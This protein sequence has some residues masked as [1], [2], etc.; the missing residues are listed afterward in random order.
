MG[1]SGGM[2][3]GVTGLTGYLGGRLGPLVRAAGHELVD[4]GRPAG[5]DLLQP[6]TLVEAVTRLRPDAVIHTAAANPGRPEDTM[7]PVNRAASA[8]LAEITAAEG[9]RLV[10]VSSD[11]VH[12]GRHAPYD[13]HAA[14]S[15]LNEYGRSKAAGETAVLAV[16][17]AAVAVRTSLIYGVHDI[18]RSTA[19]FIERLRSGQRL[20]LFADVIRQ[21]V[22][23]EAL[24]EALL[25]LA[26][27]LTDVA[28]PL[29]VA[30][31]QPI[32]R[33]A[34]GRR[35]LAHWGVDAGAW[36]GG[37]DD[38]AAAELSDA[39][40]LDLRLRLDRA[41]GLG[42]HCPGVDEVLSGAAA[43]RAGS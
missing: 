25:R 38:V 41:L 5:V 26:V 33:A 27:E 35:M 31:C 3:I 30:G 11:V 36:G 9:V 32:D 2:R 16:H 10:H 18:D 14:P 40:P 37:I 4:L 7:D 13:D 28:G 22:W 15:P 6:P 24:A 29:N 19:G 39:I 1:N 12:D 21:P 43:G 34:F 23:V 17:P 42:L 8:A 20:S